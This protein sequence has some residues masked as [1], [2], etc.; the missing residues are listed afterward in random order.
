M[1]KWIKFIYDTAGVTSPG[2]EYFT[3]RIDNYVEYSMV[4]KVSARP[5]CIKWPVHTGTY[6]GI[7]IRGIKEEGEICDFIGGTVLGTRVSV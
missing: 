3:L 6:C 1:I 7:I 5:I 4:A 2:N